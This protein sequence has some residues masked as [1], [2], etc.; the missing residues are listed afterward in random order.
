MPWRVVVKQLGLV[1][2]ALGTLVEK[3]RAR[4]EKRG[5]PGENC[6][7]LRAW[8]ALKPAR[9]AGPDEVAELEAPP[10]GCSLGTA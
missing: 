10:G 2:A 5:G 8:L 3:Q 6:K 9:L 7:A 1:E 4:L